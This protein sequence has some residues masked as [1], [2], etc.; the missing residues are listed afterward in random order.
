VGHVF[1]F[2]ANFTWPWAPTQ[3]PFSWLKLFWNLGY[4]GV[5]SP[6]SW[7]GSNIFLGEMFDFRRITLFCW[8]KRLSK[9]KMTIR[10]YCRPPL[11]TP[12]LGH[13]LRF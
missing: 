12:M 9:H 10:S 4:S 7:G 6:K 13:H 3:E 11:A 2:L 1:A 5:A 8:E